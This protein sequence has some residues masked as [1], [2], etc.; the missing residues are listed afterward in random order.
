MG[1]WVVCM[2]WEGGWEGAPTLASSS[3]CPMATPKHAALMSEQVALYL[4][5]WKAGWVDGLAHVYTSKCWCRQ[6]LLIDGQGGGV[7]MA[8]RLG[9]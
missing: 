8:G 7:L 4:R 6:V 3:W 9:G 1:R 5:G 2:W